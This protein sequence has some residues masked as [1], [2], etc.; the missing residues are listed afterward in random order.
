MLAALPR[1]KSYVQSAGIRGNVLLCHPG[2]MS[3][4]LPNQLD[5]RVVIFRRRDNVVRIRVRRPRRNVLVASDG[6]S[7]GVLHDDAGGA[8]VGVEKF[9]AATRRSSRGGARGVAATQRQTLQKQSG[10]EQKLLNK[11]ETHYGQFEY[12]SIRRMVRFFGSGTR[13]RRRPRRTH[14]GMLRRPSMGG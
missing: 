5:L 10:R 12:G 4:A 3:C 1:P 6:G 7:G 2:S 11:T 13:Q 9:L 8:V 14:K